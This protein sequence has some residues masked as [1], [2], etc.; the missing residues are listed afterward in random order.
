MALNP[1]YLLVARLYIP[2]AK[3]RGQK[4]LYYTVNASSS[5]RS[6]EETEV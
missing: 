6:L 1:I 5:E 4:T 3:A 2:D